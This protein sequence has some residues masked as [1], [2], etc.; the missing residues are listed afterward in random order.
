[1]WAIDLAD[2]GVL[3]LFDC[4][5]IVVMDV[6]IEEVPKEGQGTDIGG[7]QNAVS[8]IFKLKW[9]SIETTPQL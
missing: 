2:D 7:E 6:F 3:Q 5:D 4:L 1:M 9:A 8:R